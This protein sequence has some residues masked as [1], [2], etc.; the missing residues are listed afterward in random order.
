MQNE[1]SNGL[2]LLEHQ[3]WE[4]CIQAASQEASATMSV[5]APAIIYQ[6]GGRYFICTSFPLRYV[7]ERV[8][9]DN[10]QKGE[11]PENHINRPLI[12]EH[13]RA[14]TNYLL[15][16]D[17]YILPPLSL[18]IQDS[19]RCH[20]I[21]SSS[22]IKFS[23]V[24]M[25]ISTVF[26]CSDGQHRIRAIQEALS[27]S[28]KLDGDSI[29][30]TI[31]VE[32][33]IEVIH[34]DFFDCAQSKAIPASLLTIFN[35]R[36]PLA[37]LVRDISEIVPIF[38]GRIEKAAKS[39]GKSSVQILTLNQLRACVAEL[40]VGDSIQHSAVLARES[41]ARLKDEQSQAEHERLIVDFFEKFTAANDQWSGLLNSGDPALGTVDTNGLRQDFV[42]F[43]ATGLVIM[44]RI[45]YAIRNL[46]ES[47]R[48]R[49][50]TSLAS[51]IDWRRS[52]PMWQGNIIT[53]DGGVKTQRG[54]VEM[55]VIAVKQRLGIALSKSE[56]NRLQ[57]VSDTA[58]QPKPALS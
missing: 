40:L 9:I 46:P 6:Q 35:R 10:L 55:A 12:P 26:Q 53:T 51:E 22:A 31:V 47:E 45:G 17:E 48:T 33:N 27:K 24:C 18:C 37:K 58:A 50:I 32:S 34:R 42:H 30:I 57:R 49:L 8:H 28:R 1:N 39:V 13:V 4:A 14:I 25:P 21:A 29:A 5:V 23:V 19:V 41:A 38:H 44:G 15:T 7:A 16:Q 11:L 20:V 36:E 56:E 43:T 54:P 3:T 2:V 52:A